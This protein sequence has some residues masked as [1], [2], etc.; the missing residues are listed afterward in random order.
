MKAFVS[1]E[2][3]IEKQVFNQS[4]SI[5]SVCNSLLLRQENESNIDGLTQRKKA[6]KKHLEC[7]CQSV[8]LVSLA[9]ILDWRRVAICAL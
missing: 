8:L 1:V 2:N 5:F 9:S 3:E 7:M 4:L 6:W